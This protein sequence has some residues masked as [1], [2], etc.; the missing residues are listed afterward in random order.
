MIVD[1]IFKA[2]VAIV[3]LWNHPSDQMG[4]FYQVRQRVSSPLHLLYTFPI[5]TGYPSTQTIHILRTIYFEF[6]QTLSLSN[7][8][9]IY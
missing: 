2:G 1:T 9:S 7:S 8:E 3:K 5:P 6:A 4:R